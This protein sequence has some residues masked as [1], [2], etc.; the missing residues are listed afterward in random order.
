[1]MAVGKARRKAMPLA[2]ALQRYLTNHKIGYDLILHDETPSSTRTAEACHVSG[3]C[4]AKGVL[5][6]DH[7]GYLL[8]VLPTTHRIELEDLRTMLGHGVELA[9]ETEVATVFKD[10]QRG[11]VPPIGACYGLDTIVD[12]SLEE[13]PDIYFEAGDHATLVHVS[14][15]QFAKLVRRAHHGRFSTREAGVA[16]H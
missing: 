3:D 1:M 5:L 14:R 13:Q 16:V 9:E 7:G 4:L 15:E 10:C 11:A 2:A 6:R 12:D 8:A